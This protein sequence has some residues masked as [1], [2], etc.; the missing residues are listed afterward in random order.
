MGCLAICA[1]VASLAPLSSYVVTGSLIRALNFAGQPSGGSEVP[2]WKMLLS[3]NSAS[4]NG[5]RHA[6]NRGLSEDATGPREEQAGRQKDH[7]IGTP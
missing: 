3:V 6:S 2:N 4:K 5:P 7:T 1:V